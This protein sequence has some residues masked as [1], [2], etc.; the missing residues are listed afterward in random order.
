LWAGKR[1]HVFEVYQKREGMV[2][3]RLAGE[4]TNLFYFL[5]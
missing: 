3:G 4:E 2:Q 1:A 5:K